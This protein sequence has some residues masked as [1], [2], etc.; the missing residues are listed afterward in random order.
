MGLKLW[1]TSGQSL[2]KNIMKKVGITRP[3]LGA[4]LLQRRLL[5]EPQ[6]EAVDCEKLLRFLRSPLAR[7]IR[8][9]GYVLREYRFAL[10]VPATVYEPQAG[11]GEEM[12]LQ[13]VVDCCFETADGLVVVDFKTDRIRPGEEA[14][15]A[16]MYRPQ[17]EAYAHALERVL[18]KKV[19]R[20]VL[21]F[22]ATNRAVTQEERS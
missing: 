22:F 19:C 9:S 3:H 4:S 16:E 10:L 21:W 6:A 15:R 13:G 5:S 18:E 11:Q 8:E 14:Q 2:G 12:L 1:P 20:R 7:E 17:L